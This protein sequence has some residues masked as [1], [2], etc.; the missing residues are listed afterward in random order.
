[1]PPKKVPISRAQD[2]AKSGK[3]FVK[4]SPDD[5][6]LLLGTDTSFTKDLGPKMKVQLPKS[7]GTVLGEVAEVISDTQVKLKREFA[8]DNGKATAK[9]RQKCDAAIEDGK[10]GLTYKILPHINQ[11]AMYR[12]VYSALKDGGCIGIFPEG[13]FPLSPCLTFSELTQTVVRR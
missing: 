9:V 8:G 10:P 6:C 4:L 7:T 3:G 5:P 13:S 1:L 12:H 11:E 2:E